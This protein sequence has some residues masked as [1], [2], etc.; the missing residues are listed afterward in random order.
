LV[1]KAPAQADLLDINEVIVETIA[2]ARSEILRNDVALQTQLAKDL[3]PI[4]GDRV[5]L[6]QV[7]M[8]LVMNAVEAMAAVNEG[9]RDLQIA[10][11]KEREDHVS[12]TVSD[13]GPILKPESLNR[14]F[15]AFCS[16]KPTGMGIGLSICRSIIEAHE[17][18]IWATANVP[19]G[20]A[21]HITLPASSKT[22]SL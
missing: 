17:G 8:N 7:I 13:S 9:A 16:T 3:P 2:L 19:R 5:Q 10:T 4:R 1:K 12:I 6:Q 20:A 18:R 22:P 21:L 15:E 14:F 11:D